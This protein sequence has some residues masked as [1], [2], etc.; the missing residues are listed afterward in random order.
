MSICPLPWRTLPASWP[1]L[2]ASSRYVLP[3]TVRRRVVAEQAVNEQ[4]AAEQAVAE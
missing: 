2:V 4:V 3:V 1:F